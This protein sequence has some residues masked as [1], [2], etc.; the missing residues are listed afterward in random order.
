MMLG[1]GVKDEELEE[2]NCKELEVRSRDKAGDN[3]KDEVMDG[4]EGRSSG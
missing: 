1:D 2:R 3:A 4:V